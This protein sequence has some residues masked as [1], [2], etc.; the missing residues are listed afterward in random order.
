M[1]EKWL[2][3]LYPWHRTLVSEGGRKSMEYIGGIL[4]LET[5]SL[6]SGTSFNGWTVPE[7]WDVES[8]T[9]SNTA[10][11]VLIDYSERNLR[12]SAY[13]A[14]VRKRVG[15][16]ELLSHLNVSEVVPDAHPYVFHYYKNDGSWSFNVT[17]A[18]YQSFTDDEYD[19]EIDVKVRPGEMLIGEVLVPGKSKEEILISTYLCHPSMYNDNLSGVVST[20]ELYRRVSAWKDSKYTYR[21][22]FLPETIGSQAYLSLKPQAIDSVVG[23][24]AMYCCGDGKLPTWKKSR[25]GESAL[26]RI[27]ECVAR[28]GSVNILDYFPGGSDERQFNGPG[29]RMPI[30]ALTTTPAGEFKEYHTSADTIPECCEENID[31]IVSFAEEALTM[32]EENFAP[33]PLYSGE[34][35][36]SAYDLAYPTQDEGIQRGS[37]Y[38]TKLVASELDGRTDLLEI[39]RR[40]DLSWG[41]VKSAAAALLGAGLIKKSEN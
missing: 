21:F 38:A 10:G 24:F 35:C 41:E 7:S 11:D 15:R 40:W 18:E 30:G 20:M 25:C 37:A 22:V 26:D 6:P 36:F 19:V 28:E 34:P 14:P 39:S 1:I 31:K 3:D 13:S 4:P 5:L 29:F 33:V 9:I 23:G 8:A 17:K 27:M 32:L 2:N 16:D 12:V